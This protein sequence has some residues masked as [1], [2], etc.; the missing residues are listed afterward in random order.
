MKIFLIGYMG[1]GKS[2]LAPRIARRLGIPCL[3]LDTEIEREEKKTISRIFEEE[4]E[5]HFRR[6]EQKMLA[7][8]IRNNKDFVL[9]TGGGTP[10]FARNMELMKRSGITL[11]LSMPAKALATRVV[12]SADRRPLLKGLSELEMQSFISDQLKERL[13]YYKKAGMTVNGL[14]VD[15]DLLIQELQLMSHAYSR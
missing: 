8:I 6:A 10:C 4:G 7:T 2:T 1:S 15:L 11:Y 14:S 12:A 5:D 3:D 13:P 9:A